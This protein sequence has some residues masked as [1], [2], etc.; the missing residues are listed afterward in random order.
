MADALVV[1]ELAEDGSPKKSTL[2][3]ISFVKAALPALGGSFAILVLGA[4]TA[5]AARELGRYGASKVLCCEDASL[6]DY[7]AEHFA[8][9]VAAV[10]K[11]YALVVATAT[12]QGKDLLPRVAARLDAAYAG[13]CSGVSADG[14]T[15]A[16]PAP[17][18]PPPRAS[19]KRRPAPVR[20]ASSSSGSIP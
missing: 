10:A 5:D 18:R 1:A 17:G 4:K 14:S 6:K 15:L 9:T 2:S 13:D 20:R 3:A 19:P 8:P 11:G 12:S 7:T 16:S